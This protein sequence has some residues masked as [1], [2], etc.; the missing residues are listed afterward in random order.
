MSRAYL[1]LGSNLGDRLAYLQSAVDALGAATPG[2]N[3][4]QPSSTVLEK[5]ISNVSLGKGIASAEPS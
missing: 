3:Y 4:L 2:S 5:A 1:G